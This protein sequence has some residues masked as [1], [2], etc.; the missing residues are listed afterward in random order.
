[1]ILACIGLILLFLDIFMGAW[2]VAPMTI[3]GIG[4]LV[5]SLYILS[6]SY[7]WGREYESEYDE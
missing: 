6:I 4:I 1:L 2:R 5:F 3:F 7:Q